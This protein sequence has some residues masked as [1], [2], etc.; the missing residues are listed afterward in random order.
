MLFNVIHKLNLQEPLKITILPTVVHFAIIQQEH[1]YERRDVLKRGRWL[2][3]GCVK[4]SDQTVRTDVELKT[5]I[6]TCFPFGCHQA[7]ATKQ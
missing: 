4:S 2:V 7:M 1:F 3:R 5:E 6:E